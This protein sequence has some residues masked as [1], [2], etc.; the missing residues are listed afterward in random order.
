MDYL[1][2]TVAILRTRWVG[3]PWVVENVPGPEVS[4]IMAPRPGEHLTTLC[5]SSFGLPI[6]RHRLFLT[7]FPV[8]PLRCDHASWPI[9]HKGKPKPIGIYHVLGDRI[10]EGGHTARTLEEGL[11]AMGV[12]RTM[13][14][15]TLKEG[16]P[17]AYSE[18]I[19]RALLV[20]LEQR[21]TE[22]VM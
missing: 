3:V 6:K 15:D 19:G 9:G 10:P 11:A 5:G 2:P 21:R 14:W 18:H 20:H 8:P 1:T 22:P 4:A 7:N 16:I 12:D 17:P 13:P